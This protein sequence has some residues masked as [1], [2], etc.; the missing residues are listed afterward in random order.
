MFDELGR[1]ELL[2]AA[3][4]ACSGLLVALS[5]VRDPAVPLGGG[6][7]AS[8]ALVSIPPVVLREIVA[9]KR[10]ANPR[11]GDDVTLADD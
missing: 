4:Y 3:T 8:V 11:F 1:G 10:L 7:L 2:V 6:L 5:A 9:T